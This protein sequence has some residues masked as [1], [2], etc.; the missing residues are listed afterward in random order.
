MT[1]NAT[2]LTKAGGPMRILLV[3]NAHMYR[4]PDGRLFTPSIYDATFF[5]RYLDVFD[6]VCFLAKTKH[7]AVIDE[8]RFIHVDIERLRIVE[9]PWYQGLRQMLGV[10]PHLFKAYRLAGLDCD[11]MIYRVCQIESF[12]SFLLRRSRVPFVLEVVNDPATFTTLPKPLLQFNIWMLRRMLHRCAGASFVTARVLQ[13]KYLPGA[14]TRDVGFFQSH[15]SSVEIRAENYRGP[16]QFPQSLKRLRIVHVANSIADDIKGH[17]TLL[18]AVS[19]MAAQGRF[20]SVRFI[21]DGPFVPALKTL[22]RETLGIEEN[23]EF[24]G[25]VHD[26]SKLFEMLL[27]ADIFVYPTQL[28]GLPRSLIEAMA[29]GLPALS[30]PIAGIPELL[31][32]EYLFEPGDHEAFA[33]KLMALMENP[34]E[35]ESMSRENLA[36]ARHYENTALNARRRRFYEQTRSAAESWPSKAS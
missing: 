15:Y 21:G 1:R 3:D 10:L 12:L 4:T 29:V 5:S 17:T 24:V 25:R 26:R 27:D 14:K 11:A 16:R 7:V 23:V 22:A 8:K 9:L 6:E 2:P 19:L 30:T 31:K 32:R 33:R 20:V 28:E 13:E 34:Q 35:M 36:V 18:R